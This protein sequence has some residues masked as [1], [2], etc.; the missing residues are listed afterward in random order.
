MVKQMNE[1]FNAAMVMDMML[2]YM[3]TDDNVV[4]IRKEFIYEFPTMRQL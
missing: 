3:C 1:G 2:V 4:F